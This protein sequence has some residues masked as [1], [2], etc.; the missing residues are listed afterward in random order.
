MRVAQGLSGKAGLLDRKNLRKFT[1]DDLPVFKQQIASIVAGPVDIA[2]EADTFLAGPAS[3]VS[4]NMLIDGKSQFLLAPLL[5]AVKNSC[6]DEEAKQTFRTSASPAHSSVVT[7]AANELLLL[8]HTAA[9][10]NK[11][12]LRCDPAVREVSHKLADKVWTVSGNFED[13]SEVLL[14]NK[15]SKWLESNI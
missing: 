8:L 9:E 15:V 3:K 2:V 6:F 13:P 7:A 11:I 5:A 10:V 4:V 14:P 1:E 12:V